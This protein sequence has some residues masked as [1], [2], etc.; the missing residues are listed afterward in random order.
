METR[1]IPLSKKKLWLLLLLS[2][3]FVGIGIWLWGK[4][5]EFVT[6]DRF[7]ARFASITCTS[8]FGA[9]IPLFAFKVIDKRPGV[10]IN[11]L[12][13]YRLGLFN[14]H[15]VIPWRHIT[16]C[17][18][19]QIQRTKLLMIHVDNVEEILQAMSPVPRWFQRL[20]VSSTGTPYSLS[21]AALQGNF[22][23]L[24]TFIETGIE[25]HRSSRD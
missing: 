4:S 2:C 18:I 17:T 10:I 23:D 25:V 7:R 11:D 12:G 14:Y 13:I 16:H 5:S 22:D 15:P 6:Y 19:T 21:A 24:K 3:L 8:F 9:C 1:S 20:T